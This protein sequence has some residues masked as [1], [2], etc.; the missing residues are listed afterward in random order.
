MKSML[1][2]WEKKLCNPVQS[3]LKHGLELSCIVDGCILIN[4]PGDASTQPMAGR[5]ADEQETRARVQRRWAVSVNWKAN[6]HATLQ[7][8]Q[9]LAETAFTVANVSNC[10]LFPARFVIRHLMS[11]LGAGSGG[12]L[13]G[14][15]LLFGGAL[16]VKVK[17]I[18]CKRCFTIALND[19]HNVVFFKKY[20]CW[21]NS[22]NLCGLIDGDFSSLL[23][24]PSAVGRGYLSYTWAAE[25][26]I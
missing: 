14:E 26:D 25:V 1:K 22:I 19:L 5:W 7:V 24:L 3:S 21:P 16:K 10:P 9:R 23:P 4:E 20:I 13:L 2:Q 11:M 18:E 8:A 17:R 12:L 6:S 15:G